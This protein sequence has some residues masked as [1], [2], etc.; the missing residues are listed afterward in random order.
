MQ[1]KLRETRVIRRISQ[2]QLRLLT[3]IHQTRISMIEN[4]LVQPREDEMTR[5]AQALG[6]RV[7]DIFPNPN[8]GGERR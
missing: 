6:V 5:L 8:E 7:E 2:F 3:S 1:N 4:N